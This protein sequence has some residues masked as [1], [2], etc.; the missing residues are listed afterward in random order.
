VSRPRGPCVG[1]SVIRVAS[2]GSSHRLRWCVQGRAFKPGQGKGGAGQCGEGS[3]VQQRGKRARALN[4]QLDGRGSSEKRE[5]LRQAAAAGTYVDGFV[6]EQEQ[7]TAEQIS[8]R[9]RRLADTA[10]T[11]V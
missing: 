2:L 10:Y 6:L 1:S 9:T 5:I 3:D 4:D 8:E 11:R 7:W